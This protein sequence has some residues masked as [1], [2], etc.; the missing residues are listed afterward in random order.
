M[1]TTSISERRAHSGHVSSSL[2]LRY[3][4]G[5]DMAGTLQHATGEMTW[6]TDAVV[7]EEPD[8]TFAVVD[9]TLLVAYRSG[10]TDWL[11][12]GTATLERAD[13]TATI[14]V[15]LSARELVLVTP[16]ST[17]RLRA[18]GDPAA[19]AFAADLLVDDEAACA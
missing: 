8:G 2:T 7:A 9:G 15:G 11:R 4:G 5:A 19:E 3:A 18:D 17:L 1:N 12:I 16:T 10:G 14:E 13:V 6:T